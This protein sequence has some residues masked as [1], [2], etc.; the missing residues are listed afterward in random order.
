[1]PYGYHHNG[2]V[3]THTLVRV[4]IAHE[5]SVLKKQ[6]KEHNVSFISDPRR[7][8]SSNFAKARWD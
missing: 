2:F 6:S 5:K 1:M 3:A 4:H 7:I 8:E